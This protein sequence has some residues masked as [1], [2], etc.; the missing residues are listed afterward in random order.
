MATPPPS[1]KS[2]S[3]LTRKVGPLPLWAWFA[4]LAVGVFFFYSRK[5]SG[6]QVQASTVQAATPETSSGLVPSAG[7]SGGGS[8][9]DQA[10]SDL[11][12]AYG[13]Q[14]SSLLD[15][16]TASESNLMQLAQSQLAYNASQTTNGAVDTST[17]ANAG[18]QPGGSNAPTFNFS[19][20]GITNATSTTKAGAA[21]A[22]AAATPSKPPTYSTYK[23]NVTLKPG[24]TVHFRTGKG[25]YAA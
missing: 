14:Q 3:P 22:K 17:G 12:S 7:S 4:I 20:P 9:S 2:G 13:S 10:T 6:S 11:L 8:G 21:K 23:R 18:S 5:G 1:S 19:F 24:Q 15:A 16:L 25:Y